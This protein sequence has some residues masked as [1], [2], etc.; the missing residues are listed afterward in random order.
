MLTLLR[1]IH[2]F[3]HSFYK[4][5]W[6]KVSLGAREQI[7]Q[8]RLRCHHLVTGVMSG[9]GGGGRGSGA[10]G[11][12]SQYDLGG[13]ITE[14]SPLSTTDGSTRESALQKTSQI[15]SQDHLWE[16]GVQDRFIHGLLTSMHF[17][18][19]HGSRS[20]PYSSGHG[21]SW[22]EE[23]PRW[24]EVRCCQLVPV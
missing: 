12:Q 21:K 14:P 24:Q 6:S 8:Q 5:R 1:I 17:W 15:V 4:T 23:V 7:L 18:A 19:W 20:G 3:L 16:G 2:L 10:G 9:A 13:C 22:E 11:R